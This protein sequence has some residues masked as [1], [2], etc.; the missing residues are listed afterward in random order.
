MRHATIPAFAA[1]M[2]GI[3]LAQAAPREFSD[4]RPLNADARLTVRNV[5]GLIEV[6]AWDKST[7][8]I[9][10]QLAD[11]VE[12]VDIT[13]RADDLR[14]EVKT[15]KSE[16]YGSYDDTQLRLRVPVGVVLT[17]D[18]TSADLMV[19]G[20]KGD[21]VARTVSGDVQIE[22]NSKRISAQ[23]V[24]GDLTV[25][26]PHAVS[27][28]VSTVSGDADVQG[29]SGELV[30][31]S[32]S[33]DVRVE[34]GVFSKL[35][36]KSVSGDVDIHGAA[37]PDALVKAESLS[38]DVRFDAPAALSAQVTLK[39][40]SGEKRCDFEGYGK[41]GDGKRAVLKVGDGRGNITLT[42]FSGD[43]SLEK[44]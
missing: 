7:L 22:V 32:V 26:A 8:D 5:A 18:G 6:E 11:N 34:G 35:E 37:A 10:A 38:G 31:E 20:L 39:T 17:L 23:T 19:R 16:R 29:A 44:R 4:N 41:V 14:V 2:L 33:G 13:G 25:L 24:S 15:K 9:A 40:F 43:V 1:L 42:S 3:G 27:T 30:A 28:K 36:L 21:L 12:K